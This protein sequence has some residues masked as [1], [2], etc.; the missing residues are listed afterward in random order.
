MELVMI[1]FLVGVIAAFAYP[2]IDSAIDEARYMECEGQLEALR[3]AKSLYT[4]DHLGKEVDLA[5]NPDA[6][7]V[8]E[9]YFVTPPNFYCPRVGPGVGAEYLQPYN[10][11]QVSTCPYCSDPANIPDGVRPF[12]AAP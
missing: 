10:L 7:A 9:S 11:Y 1:V 3:R 6:I 12:N 8:F 2:Y 4:V 5:S